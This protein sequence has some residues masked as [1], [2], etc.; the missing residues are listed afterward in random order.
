MSGNVPY[1]WYPNDRCNFL[2]KVYGMY[3]DYSI[4]RDK[5]IKWAKKIQKNWVLSLY[6]S[7]FQM[8]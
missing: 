6:I 4:F 3:F 5:K 2:I 7:V 8:C 1:I